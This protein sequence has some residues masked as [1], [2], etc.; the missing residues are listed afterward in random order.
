MAG[1]VRL[2]EQFGLRVAELGRDA[3]DVAQKLMLGDAAEYEDL[4]ETI[5]DV[6]MKVKLWQGL[7]DF[8]DCTIQNNQ[9]VPSRDS[10]PRGR[11]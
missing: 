8:T 3:I 10:N 5:S 11:D 6:S 4:E 2:D 9:A 1:V 7:A